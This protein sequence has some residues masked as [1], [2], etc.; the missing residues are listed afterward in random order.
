MFQV[1][2]A[3]LLSELEMQPVLEHGLLP[4]QHPS[5]IHIGNHQGIRMEIKGLRLP[6]A[7]IVLFCTSGHITQKGILSLGSLPASRHNGIHS[8]GTETQRVEFRQ[9][10]LYLHIRNLHIDLEY[11]T[12]QHI[13]TLDYYITYI[14]DI[15]IGTL[16]LREIHTY[17]DIRSHLPC[18]SRRIVIPQ[19]TVHQHHSL[20]LHRCKHTWDGHRGA[21]G[22]IY[23]SAMPY[24]RLS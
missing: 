14:V 6:H 18:E 17:Y 8:L 21:H 15:H 5:Y 19:A 24:L 2:L 3:Y 10:G 23:L 22:I 13:Q 20:G 11:I 7:D 16:S 1:T 9:P 12:S 4:R